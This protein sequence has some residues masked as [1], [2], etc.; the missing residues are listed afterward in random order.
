MATIDEINHLYST[1]LGGATPTASD[2]AYWQGSGLAGDNLYNT[3]QGA[4]KNDPRYGTTGVGTGTNATP[5]A[6]GGSGGTNQGMTPDQISSLIS[7]SLG[8]V[9]SAIEG[10]GGSMTNGFNT[11]N[12]NLQTGFNNVN[13]NLQ[14]GFGTVNQNLGTLGDGLNQ[15][16]TNTAT[17]FQSLNKANE[18]RATAQASQATDY[19]NQLKGL[20]GGLKDQLTGLGTNMNNYYT[21]LAKTGAGIQS[22][23]DNVG[24][25]L[26]NF[27]NDY[28]RRTNLSD[29]K[30]SEILDS[31]AGTAANNRQAMTQGFNQMGAQIAG[32]G[33]N[34]YGGQ[35]QAATPQGSVPQGG[36]QAPQQGNFQMALNNA[37]GVVSNPQGN[38]PALV[39]QLSEFVS[40]F[41][42]NGQLIQQGPDAQGVPTFR[43]MGPDGILQ[44]AKQ[45]PQGVQ[46]VG[47]LNVNQIVQMLGG[48]Q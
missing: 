5:G 37:R 17:G 12:Q 25:D 14:T 47:G 48:Q 3:F 44:I 35:P 2:Y 46:F 30:R 36:Q 29:Q 9:N 40:A 22:S 15:L 23:V 6:T 45:G 28:T 18:D 32:L 10:L 38:N 31:V 21:D 1:M 26:T 33:R 19:F 13:N 27:Q 34:P 8:G 20:S 4:A 43:N 16:N 41:D 7:G 42:A 11:T 24:S 39:S